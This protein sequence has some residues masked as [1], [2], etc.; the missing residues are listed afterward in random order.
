[1]TAGQYLLLYSSL[2]GPAT[3]EAHFLA[4]EYGGGGGGDV[5]LLKEVEMEVSAQQNEVQMEAVLDKEVT[6]E[7]VAQEQTI[8]FEATWQRN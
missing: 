3:A 1:M 5:Y 7:V 6:F 2:T 8:K 4:V